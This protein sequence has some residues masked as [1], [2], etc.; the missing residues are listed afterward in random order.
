[1]TTRRKALVST[2]LDL[3]GQRGIDGVSMDD[4]A[5]GAGVTKGSLYW[6]FDTKR[7]VILEAAT[8]YYEVW[9][10]SMQD[11]VDRAESHRQAL[12][13][14]IQYSVRSCLLDSGNRVFTTELIA[15]SLH[16]EGFRA[17]WAG[18][19]DEALRLFLGLTH[20]AV[21]SGQIVCDDVD[22]RVDVMLAAMEGLKQ[23]ALFNPA[24]VSR[25]REDRLCRQLLDLLAPTETASLAPGRSAVRPLRL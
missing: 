4:I 23:T 13:A 11:V 9:R 7:E 25:D 2:A 1:M 6:H 20:R 22:T 10:I 19:Y 3:F 24:L 21:G 15:L 18:F 12:E 17:S 5:G 16:D 14:A 8:L